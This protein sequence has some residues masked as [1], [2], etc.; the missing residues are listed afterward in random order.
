M[1]KS[2]L[3]P[4]VIVQ[5]IQ[6]TNASFN[7]TVQDLKSLEAAGVPKAVIEA[8]MKGGGSGMKKMM[9]QMEAMKGKGGF[10]GM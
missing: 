3:P 1:H 10:P 7:L 2:G 6:S 5:T 8:M 9:R 4:Q